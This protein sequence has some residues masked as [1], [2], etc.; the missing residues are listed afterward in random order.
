LATLLLRAADSSPIKLTDRSVSVKNR[1][2][3]FAAMLADGTGAVL[4]RSRHD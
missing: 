3:A 4:L 2:R 1:V